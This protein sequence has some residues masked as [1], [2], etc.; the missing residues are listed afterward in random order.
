[1]VKCYD[2][3]GNEYLKEPIDA[4]ECVEHCG[5]TLEPPEPKAAE[6]AKIEMQEIDVVIPKIR[7]AGR[8]ANKK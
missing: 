6:A 4:R 2:L 1:M 5:F 7:K 3:E 8:P